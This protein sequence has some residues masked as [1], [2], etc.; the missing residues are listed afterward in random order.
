MASSS[1]SVTA[2]PNAV[3]ASPCKYSLSPGSVI[4]GAEF[5][6]SGSGASGGAG[7]GAA[8]VTV[9][10]KSSVTSEFTPSLAVTVTA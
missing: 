2:I 6:G 3:I 5:V 1:G 9:T 10:V 4:T 7:A 8:A